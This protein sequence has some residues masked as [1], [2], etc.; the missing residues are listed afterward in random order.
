MTNEKLEEL[1]LQ[2]SADI[3]EIKTKM[4]AD[5]RALYGNGKP[6]LLSDMAELERRMLTME[7][8]VSAIRDSRKRNWGMV[9]AIAAWVASAAVNIIGAWIQHGR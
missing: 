9:V 4:D 7:N 5:Y 8:A 1:L 6:G 3:A 2:M